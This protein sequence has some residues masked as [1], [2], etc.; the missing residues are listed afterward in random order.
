MAKRKKAVTKT[1]NPVAL[2]S[3]KATTTAA[4]LSPDRAGK[5]PAKKTKAE[6]KPETRQVCFTDQDTGKRWCG[7]VTEVPK[8]KSAPKVAGLRRRKR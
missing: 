5:A 8:E 7:E 1:A 4:N 6:P 3:K 2:S